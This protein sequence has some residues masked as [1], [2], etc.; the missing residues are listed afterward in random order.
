[1]SDLVFGYCSHCSKSGYLHEIGKA[2][3]CDDDKDNLQ[4]QPKRVKKPRRIN[5]VSNKRKDENKNYN[6]VRNDYLNKNPLC[7]CCNGDAT[8]IH[9]KAKRDS[10]LLTDTFTFMAICRSCHT[11][12][13][14]NH[15]YALENDY[16]WSIEKTNTYLKTKK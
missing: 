4:Y 12:I 5:P 10:G 3:L 6:E 13:H 9:H 8:E 2:L 7:E 1:M 11:E 15:S 14:S 16:V